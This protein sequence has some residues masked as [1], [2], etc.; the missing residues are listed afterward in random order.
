MTALFNGKKEENVTLDGKIIVDEGT[1][2]K[3]GV[4][5]VGPTIIGKNCVIENGTVIGE[6]TSIGD[7][8]HLSY[9]TVSNSIIMSNCIIDGKLNIKN[10]IIASNSKI[11]KKQDNEKN[12]LLGEGTQIYI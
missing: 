12:F 8:S 4:K 9:C 1:I 5:I 10:S 3:N 11:I 7:D 2:I 6:N